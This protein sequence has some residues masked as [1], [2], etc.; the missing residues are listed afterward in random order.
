MK[1]AIFAA[2]AALSLLAAPASAITSYVTTV[3]YFPSGFDGTSTDPADGDLI[4]IEW[5]T[6]VASGTVQASDLVDL[7]FTLFG[8]DTNELFRDEAII[9][10]VAQPVGGQSRSA[11]GSAPCEILFE[12]DLDAFAIE[13]F[14][15]LGRFDS[16][17]GVD[18]S[19][20]DDG[21]F[22]LLASNGLD[23]VGAFAFVDKAV[24]PGLTTRAREFGVLTE[25]APVQPIPLPAP[26]LMLLSALGA[27]AVAARRKAGR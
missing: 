18:A 16:G 20:F 4:V 8:S 21:T 12:F 10:G 6:A 22:Y 11:C 13:A 14:D 24:A 25:L 1:H 23:S 15:G 9:G 2:A 3:D 5:S 7:T 27:A 26:A 17:D 19:Q